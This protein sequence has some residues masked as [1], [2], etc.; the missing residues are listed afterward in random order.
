M[1]F[2]TVTA[3]DPF[4]LG[5]A[6]IKRKYL[7]RR[8]AAYG[9]E[10]EIDLIMRNCDGPHECELRMKTR[11]VRAQIPGGPRP[12]AARAAAPPLA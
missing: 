11:F 2:V 6:Q 10:I 5:S 12:P 8:H 9:A 4:F 1:E 7:I 3:D